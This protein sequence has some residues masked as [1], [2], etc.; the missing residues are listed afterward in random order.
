MKTK[1]I[2]NIFVLALILTTAFGCSK[3]EDGPK[4]S[5]RSV[6][7]RIYGTYRIEYI[8]KNGE[9]LTNYWKSYYDLS[10][11]IYSPYYE[12]PDDSPS[13]EVSGFIECNDSLISYA[14]G[15]QTFIQIDK[16]V[17][18]PMKNHM[19]DT[20]WYPGRHFY[21]LLMTPEEGSVNF[22]ITRLTDN[23]MWLFLDDDRDVY[24]IKFKE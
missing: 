18:I 24:E 21:P 23:E 16:D 8:S 3:F 19:I 17:Y 13:L 15:Y 10:F 9:D 1:S 4:V 7:K 22:K 5:F 6:M 11:K 14:T 12:R 20:S 2:R